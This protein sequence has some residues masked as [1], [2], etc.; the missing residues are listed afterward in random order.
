M[1]AQ[2]VARDAEDKRPERDAVADPFATLD[3][4][5]K[6]SAN[7]IVGTLADLVLE[8]PRDR[9]SVAIEQL[10]AGP[11]RARSP[12]LEQLRVDA[13]I[14]H[15]GEDTRAN[16]VRGTPSK[17]SARNPRTSLPRRRARAGAPW[18]AERLP[19]WGMRERM[20]T[21]SRFGRTSGC[22]WLDF[23]APL[24][25]VIYSAPGRREWGDL[26]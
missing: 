6:K 10:A 16:D 21:V 9:V 18:S 23:A 3:D 19:G 7:Q 4:H 25:L 2:H 26:G 11:G 5:Q 13:P 14:R 22:S 1:L 12:G 15:G 8:E 17:R 20:R 24:N